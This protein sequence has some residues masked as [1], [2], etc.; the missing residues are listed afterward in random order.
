MDWASLPL[1]VL[2]AIFRQLNFKDLLRCA[3]VCRS[4]NRALFECPSLAHR[5]VFL[6]DAAHT[7]QL[8]QL[9]PMSE[10]NYRQ[11]AIGLTVPWNE[12]IKDCF[13]Q[14]VQ[15][16][17]L[18][19]VSLVGEP[20]KVSDC[21]LSNMPFFGALTELN[22]EFTL[23]RAWPE[24]TEIQKVELSQLRK[25]HYL[26]V[27]TG[28]NQMN[29]LY[30]FVLPKVEQVSLVLD[31]LAN[32]EA[33][34][35]EDPL[36]E[37]SGCELLRSLEV[38]LNGTMWEQFF[39]IHKPYMERLVIRRAIDEYQ[40]RDWDLEF[41]KMPNLRYVEFTFVNNEM[42]ASLNRKCKKIEKLL[43]N[44]FCLD[45]GNFSSSMQFPLLKSLHMDG[46]LNGSLFSNELSL[47]LDKTEDLVWKYVELAP[48]QGA[49]TLV[50]PNVKRLTLRG[51]EYARFELD[52]G[53]RLESLDMDY[54][55]TQLVAPNFL[56]RLGHLKHLVLHISG[57]SA[58]L[59]PKLCHLR[60]V[61][62]LEVV[63]CTESYGYDCSALFESI[64]N[65]LTEL[66]EFILRNEHENPLMLD[67]KRYRKL[68]QLTQL[69][70]LNLQY[71]T[72]YN[73]T[74]TT[75]LKHVPHLNVW[76]CST[77]TAE[78][79]APFRSSLMEVES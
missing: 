24:W 17:N 52:I 3:L 54:Y 57:R 4:W 45:D 64:C 77:S 65:N 75:E 71:I 67:Y 14:A 35:W 76:G 68:C 1:E 27:Y 58:L 51:C 15:Q 74:G 12:D 25:M 48:A 47:T 32:E 19:F 18:R 33:M 28:A 61:K 10:R 72:I 8:R 73:V 42:L 43:I 44:G 29:T 49:F 7:D 53:N 9:I 34:Y 79:D 6:F 69:K 59:A 13:D 5:V 39:A 26:Q 2:E 78:C 60:H 55:G 37:L 38:D 23:T 16:W 56:N 40:N 62:R 36:I 21:L 20:D 22:L 11:L 46:W 50:S 30:H 31:S 70:V 41:S 66:E 63:C